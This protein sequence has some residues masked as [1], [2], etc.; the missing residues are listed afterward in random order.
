MWLE[1]KPT[2]RYSSLETGFET[3]VLTV[4]VSKPATVLAQ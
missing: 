1:E 4:D 3:P 2:G